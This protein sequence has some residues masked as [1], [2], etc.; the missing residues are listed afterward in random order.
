MRI[1]FFG[2]PQ[3]AST[4]LQ[5]LIDK[6]VDVAAVVTRPDKPRG[7][8]KEPAYSP[9]KELA[10]SQN[11]PLYQPNKASE[12]EFADF[13]KTFHADFFIVAA[14]A[15]IL[16][17]NILEIPRLGCLNVHGSILPKY[18]G[19]APV[20][21][22]IMA[23]EKETGVTI[24]KMALQMDAGDILAIEKTEIPID[25]TAGE[26]ME[27]LA[28]LGRVALFEVMQRMVQGKMTPIKQD[29]TQV[30]FAKKIKPEDAYIEWNLPAET[31]HNQIR[32]VTPNPGAWCWI[33][34]RGEKKRLLVKKTL[35]ETSLT[36]PPGGI[37][38]QNPTEL[39]VGCSKGSL[40]LL[41]IQVEGKKS[42]S[43]DVFLRGVALTNIKFL[44]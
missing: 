26:L 39:V 5:F 32:G 1:V 13:L 14:Y 38:S 11:L 22:A 31:L 25:M 4:I 6:K 36:G 24:M 30:S 41:E 42:L 43:A 37:L 17:E 10:L 16:K 9:V 44:L 7:R 29:P 33:E 3:F 19:A 40:R 20:Q 2:T 34:I 35:P 28:N 27:V 15:E 8:S 18:R 12:P 21:R 23:G